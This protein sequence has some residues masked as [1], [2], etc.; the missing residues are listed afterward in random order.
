MYKK[1][2]EKMKKVE[3]EIDEELF[4]DWKPVAFRIPEEGEYYAH[5]S[6]ASNFTLQPLMACKNEDMAKLIIKKKE[7]GITESCDKTLKNNLDVFIYDYSGQPLASANGL[8]VFLE[9]LWIE[10]TNQER[11]RW[12]KEK[13]KQENEI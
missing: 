1:G 11:T 10:A 8:R 7:G 2:S 4:G 3:I 6:S 5:L 9:S 13:E 12:L